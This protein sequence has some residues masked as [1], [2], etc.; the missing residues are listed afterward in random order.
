[1]GVSSR[2]RSV[3]TTKVV[4]VE[5]SRRYLLIDASLGRLHL[6][7]CRENW[8]R[9]SPERV[10]F[11]VTRVIKCCA[12]A[13]L[14]H[15][16]FV[17]SVY[18]RTSRRRV[19]RRT[20]RLL[21]DG[22]FFAACENSCTLFPSLSRGERFFSPVRTVGEQQFGLFRRRLFVSLGPDLRPVLMQ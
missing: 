10:C 6:P 5:I 17:V 12:M 11:L 7:R 15:I 18:F 4:A 19:Y 3:R 14:A 22:S 8:R 13:A 21:R 9:N 20:P 2:P 1:M 16:S